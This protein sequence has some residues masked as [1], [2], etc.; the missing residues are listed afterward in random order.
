MMRWLRSLGWFGGIYLLVGT[1]LV[2]VYL[3]ATLGG[4]E[5][6]WWISIPT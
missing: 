5:G 4:W 2:G 3:A 1:G 6:R